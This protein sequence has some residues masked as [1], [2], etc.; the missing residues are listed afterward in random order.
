M[1][2]SIKGFASSLVEINH[3]ANPIL[4]TLQDQRYNLIARIPFILCDFDCAIF[5]L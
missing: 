2:N 4:L 3:T 1:Y 5:Y